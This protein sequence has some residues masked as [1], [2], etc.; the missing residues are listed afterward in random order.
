MSE[1]SSNITGKFLRQI[2]IWT[3]I[4]LFIS[5]LWTVFM[6]GLVGG[7]M[8]GYPTPS[9]VLWVTLW[10]FLSFPIQPTWAIGIIIIGYRRLKEKNFQKDSTLKVATTTSTAAVIRV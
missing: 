10:Y 6:L 9:L 3:V 7:I 4:L 2:G 8:G 1:S 5:F